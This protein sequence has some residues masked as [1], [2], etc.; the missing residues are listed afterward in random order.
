MAKPKPPLDERRMRTTVS[1]QAK[2]V[3]AA[4]RVRAELPG[5]LLRD[6]SDTV[7]RALYEYLERQSPGVVA[8]VAA[9]LRAE[10][11]PAEPVVLKVAEPVR[12]SAQY[13]KMAELAQK[14]LAETRHETPA[15]PPPAKPRRPGA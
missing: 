13:R 7:A 9:H 2:L 15:P 6:F 10:Y 12:R 8:R 5:L 4:D 1:L 3:M 14:T 11:Q